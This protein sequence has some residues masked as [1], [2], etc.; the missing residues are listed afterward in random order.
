M[1]WYVKVDKKPVVLMPGKSR[2]SYKD[3]YD[4]TALAVA[5]GYEET[6]DRPML[7]MGLMRVL[8]R[9]TK[10]LAMKRIEAQEASASGAKKRWTNRPIKMT[11]PGTRSGC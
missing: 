6:Q 8:E 11:E 7:C 9:V 10:I 3:F 1:N 4:K 2:D 5:L